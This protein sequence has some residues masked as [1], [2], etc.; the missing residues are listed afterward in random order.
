MLKKGATDVS[1]KA[2]LL[3]HILVFSHG[4]WFILFFFYLFEWLFGENIDNAVVL[5]LII[6]IINH[7]I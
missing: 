2:K 1:F 4:S 5:L 6:L 7:Q 3:M